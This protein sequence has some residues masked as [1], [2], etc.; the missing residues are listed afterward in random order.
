MPLVYW[1]DEAYRL[2]PVRGLNEVKPGERPR[3]LLPNDGR[4]PLT[5]D[6]ERP[7]ASKSSV[8]VKLAFTLS[9]QSHKPL[10]RRRW[11]GHS[12]PPFGPER[13]WENFSSLPVF[14]PE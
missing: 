10:F 7:H 6:R 4:L 3:L 8:S 9:C 2:V 14:N 12:F 5:A 1:R 11:S 13:G